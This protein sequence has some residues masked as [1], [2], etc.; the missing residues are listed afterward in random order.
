MQHREEG[1]SCPSCCEDLSSRETQSNP[2]PL[3]KLFAEVEGPPKRGSHHQ[4]LDHR[5]VWVLGG[6]P[7]VPTE[8]VSVQVRQ[9]LGT[10]PPL[11]E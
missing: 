5:H 7:Q 6:Q 9:D 10:R 1:E 4:S 3:K 11:P 2:E 8:R